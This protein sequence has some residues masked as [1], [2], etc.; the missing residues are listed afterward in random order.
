MS[1]LPAPA[2]AWQPWAPH[3]ETVALS[4]PL[5]WFDAILVEK[6]HQWEEDDRL[7]REAEGK[8][9]GRR[10]VDLDGDQ[11]MDVQDEEDEVSAFTDPLSFH[12]LIGLEL[13]PLK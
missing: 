3:F 8:K 1:L 2:H 7:A 13:C 6:A 11:L 9:M 12:V 5:R 10:Q 4:C